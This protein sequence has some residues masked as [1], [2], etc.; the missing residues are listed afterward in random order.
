MRNT[1]LYITLIAALWLTAC[2]DLD[3]TPKTAISSA[4]FFNNAKELDIA[5]NGL[6]DKQLWK[7]DRDFWTDDMHHRGGGAT[8]DISRATLNSQSALS[9]EY[10]RDLYDGIKRANTLLEEMQK[11]KGN[12][13]AGVF[14]RVEG[15]ARAIRAY[16]Y[17]IL[18]TKFGDVPLITTR[19]GAQE[20]LSIERTPQAQ[21][22]KFVYDELD[23]AAA[24]LPNTSDNR[25]TQGFAHGIKARIALYVGDYNTARDA[26]KAVIDLKTYSLDASYDNLFLKSGASSPEHIYF[27]PQSFAFK[28]TTDETT[29]RD[30]LPRNAGGFGAEMPTWEAVHSFECTDG[31][32]IDESPLYDPHHPFAD[33]DPRLLASVVEFGASWL[34]YRYQ[35]HPDTLKVKN[36]RN[37]TLVNNNDSRGVS[38]FAAY[39]GFLWRKGVEQSW[40]DNR[41]ADSNIIIL[42]YADVLL[43][44]AEA[45][46]ELNQ[47]LDKAQQA[48]NQ[49]RARAYKTTVDNTAAYPAVTELDQDGLRVRVRRERRVELML[50]GLRYQD[51]IRWRIA[52]KALDKKLIG[53]PNPADQ[54]RAQWPFTDVILPDVDEDGVVVFDADALIQGK[55][56]RL[57][58]DYDFDESR[59][60]L[61]PVPA[62]DRLLNKNLSQNPNY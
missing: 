31:L 20:A 17:G 9:G 34:G 48:I 37:N 45:L 15:E 5:L 6:Y 54:D 30:F 11:A 44:Y 24:V 1:T 51:L 38:N 52:K 62:S 39:T 43:I 58:Q 60:Y 40:A 57:L 27:V 59:M 14:S 19:L 47:E 53:L 8:N 46:I 25:A 49:V 23:A 28:V 26:A 35:P 22:L 41:M 4:N 55:F 21:V 3:V 61:W 2:E 50:E 13:D 18:I 29:T 42:R 16:F 32:P 36:L 33:R 12:V 56:A 7:V 10:W